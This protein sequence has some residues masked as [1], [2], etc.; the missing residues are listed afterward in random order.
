MCAER[1][2]RSFTGLFASLV[3]GELYIALGMVLEEFE[4]GLLTVNVI[5]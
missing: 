3:E 4:A 1:T 5:L 2:S